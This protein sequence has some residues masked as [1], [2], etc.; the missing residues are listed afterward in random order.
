M[1]ET[2]PITTNAVARQ[3]NNSN[4]GRGSN[5][6]CTPRGNNLNIYGSRVICQFCDTPGHVVK[7][8]RK[9]QS[10]FP[11]FSQ[12]QP[13]RENRP[14]QNNKPSTNFAAS[15]SDDTNNWLVDSGAS[16]HITSNLQNLSRHSDYKSGEDVLLGDGNQ[17]CVSRSGSTTLNSISRPFILSDVLYV[18]RMKKN[19]ISVYKLCCSNNVSVEFSPN[20]FVVKDYSTGEQ[21]VEGQP[22]DGGG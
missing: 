1:K 10:A 4:R 16:H 15:S 6:P 12:Q 5:S 7:Q 13:N 14:A 20:S 11:W 2:M 18:P 19:L 22:K 3:N 9:L 17:L 8:C 21:L